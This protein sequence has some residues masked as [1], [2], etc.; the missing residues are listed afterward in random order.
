MSRR[1]HDERQGA[2]PSRSHDVRHALGQA[3]IDIDDAFA[4]FEVRDKQECKA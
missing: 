2:I 3:S 1:S 4:R